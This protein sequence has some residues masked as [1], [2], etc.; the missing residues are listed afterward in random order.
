MFLLLLNFN[1][2]TKMSSQKISLFTA[3]MLNINVI[4]GAGI[5]MTP[6]AMAG[7]SG[8]MSFLGWPLCGLIFF[9]LQGDQSPFEVFLNR[10]PANSFGEF[11]NG[12]A[13]IDLGKCLVH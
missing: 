5:L 2:G 12:R 8:N 7:L 3:T 10:C 6:A 13:D 1:K 9:Q 11:T 4:V